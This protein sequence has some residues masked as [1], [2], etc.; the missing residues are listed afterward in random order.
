MQGIA[1]RA[2]YTR[3]LKD[4][5]ARCETA[6]GR[7]AEH[8]SFIEAIAIIVSDFSK[9]KNSLFCGRLFLKMKFPRVERYYHALDGGNDEQDVDFSVLGLMFMPVLADM[10]KGGELLPSLLAAVASEG[11]SHFFGALLSETINAELGRFFHAATGEGRALIA[12][13]SLALSREG[14]FM[15]DMVRASEMMVERT[16]LPKEWDSTE[17][18][19]MAH[20]SR[21]LV[22]ALNNRQPFSKTKRKT[23]PRSFSTESDGSVLVAGSTGSPAVSEMSKESVEVSVP[24]E[25]SIGRPRASTA[26]RH[27]MMSEESEP[28]E[29]ATGGRPAADVFV[30]L[31]A[32]PRSSTPCCNQLSRAASEI[33]VS[34]GICA[35]R[36]FV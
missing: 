10:S 8:A 29:A 24:P 18:Q 26:F 20:L 23:R 14:S 32:Q 36:L 21:A 31:P 16:Q 25:A 3:Y 11:P 6:G 2:D 7:Y 5:A 33:A 34:A 17:W 30:S 15:G 4:L 9:L 19:T 22:M 12:D 35:L 1:T 27:C 13:A 28:A